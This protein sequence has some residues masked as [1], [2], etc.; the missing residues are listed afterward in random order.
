MLTKHVGHNIDQGNVQKPSGRKPKH[1]QR[2]LLS[3]LEAHGAP[4]KRS[5]SG[6]PLRHEC[7]PLGKP[8]LL[9]EHGKVADLMRE[10]VYCHRKDGAHRHSTAP[11][12]RDGYGEPVSEIVQRVSPEVEQRG[13]FEPEKSGHPANGFRL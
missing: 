7:A 3:V 5:E 8:A 1:E 10:L 12:T 2:R 6:H 11:L 9:H 4:S 13:R